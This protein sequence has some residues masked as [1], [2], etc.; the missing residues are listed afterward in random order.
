MNGL[1]MVNAY[2]KLSATDNYI[3]GGIC[4]NEV[5]FAMVKFDDLMNNL[6]LD[7]GSNKERSSMT[8]RFSFCGMLKRNV[9]KNGI[10]LCDKETFEKLAEMFGKN[11]GKAFEKLVTEHFNQVWKADNTPFYVSGDININ[12]IEYQIKTHKA[13][14]TNEK[15]LEELMA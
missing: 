4:G 6:L 5:K 11:K 13:T 7:K 3:V 14:F 12:G 10:T 8:L 15:T 9:T 1:E 2:K